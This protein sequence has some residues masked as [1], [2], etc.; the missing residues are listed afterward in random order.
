MDSCN[1]PDSV[2]IDPAV[3][4]NRPDSVLTD[5][6]HGLFTVCPDR[7]DSVHTDP[8]HGCY[9]RNFSPT[10]SLILNKNVWLYAKST[11]YKNL[12]F[13]V[14]IQEFKICMIKNPKPSISIKSI[15]CI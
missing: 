4:Y 14:Y 9:S 11:S 3:H 13:K 2:R 5:P 6:A 12:R 1:Q 7:P 8:A 10:L 15:C